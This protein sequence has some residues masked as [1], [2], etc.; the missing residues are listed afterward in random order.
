MVQKRKQT[1]Y[2]TG[3]IKLNMKQTEYPCHKNVIFKLIEKTG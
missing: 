3:N 2:Q 1:E